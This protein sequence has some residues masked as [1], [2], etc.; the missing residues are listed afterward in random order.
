MLINNNKQLKDLKIDLFPNRNIFYSKNFFNKDDK[1]NNSKFSY[2]DSCF[3]EEEGSSIKEFWG[4]SK[5]LLPFLCQNLNF[6]LISIKNQIKIINMTMNLNFPSELIEINNIKII[7]VKFIMNFFSIVNKKDRKVD[8]LEVTSNGLI[9]TSDIYEQ[10]YLDYKELEIS[11][12]NYIDENQNLSLNLNIISLRLEFAFVKFNYYNFFIPKNIQ[13]LELTKL[14]INSFH[15]FTQYLVNLNELKYLKLSL[16]S[17][18]IKDEQFEEK[19]LPFFVQK[20]S[21]KIK[22]IT[23]DTKIE[24]KK[25]QFMDLFFSNLNDSINEINISFNFVFDIQDFLNSLYSLKKKFNV[26]SKN[27]NKKF[28]RKFSD[29]KNSNNSDEDQNINRNKINLYVNN[30]LLIDQFERDINDISR[31]KTKKINL[32]LNKEFIKS[33]EIH[34]KSKS[35]INRNYE[36]EIKVN[37][38]ENANE[39]KII[40]ILRILKKLFSFEQENKIKN[41]SLILRYLNVSKQS[42]IITYNNVDN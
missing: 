8:Y 20:K 5:D 40:I 34:H 1:N 36:V 42:Q 10:Y 30:K 12:V 13:Y 32:N 15:N 35:I 24:I 26:L 25:K 37:K 4:F 2:S 39:D 33:D 31:F 28:S 27:S 9:I 16:S 23:I 17:F 18:Y 21:K 7:L 11:N 41:A 22:H 38:I 14:D 6:L 29:S 3:I 19:F